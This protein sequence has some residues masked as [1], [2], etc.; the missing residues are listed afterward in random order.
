MVWRSYRA[1]FLLSRG[2]WPAHTISTHLRLF[3][4]MGAG[5]RLDTLLMRCHVCFG[6]YF[7][8]AAKTTCECVAAKMRCSK[9]YAICNSF[10][11]YTPLNLLTST[12]SGTMYIQFYQRNTM[13]WKVL[14]KQKDLLKIKFDKNVI[15]EHI[16]T[17]S[18]LF[19]LF[20]RWST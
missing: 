12:G 16:C 13:K 2:W 9:S 15:L 6:T 4:F 3:L 17:S 5:T 20:C 19:L 8:F 7:Y 18:I 14:A 1:L 11:I 10:I